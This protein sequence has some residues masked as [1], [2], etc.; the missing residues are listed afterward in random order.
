MSDISFQC[1]ACSHDLV[2]DGRAAGMFLS[3]P[4]CHKP[5]VVPKSGTLAP[6]GARP[7]ATILPS[8]PPPA[9]P[10]AA[11]ATPPPA[12]PAT[13]AGESVAAA[14]AG[15]LQY[16]VVA[17]QDDEGTPGPVD[18][19]RIER[20]LNE[21]TA[22]GWRFRSAATVQTPDWLGHPKQS[23]LLIFDRRA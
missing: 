6:S 15:P 2:V 7:R 22:A 9:A 18:P 10:P 5:L 13:T 12:P 16:K 4:E 14:P 20:K 11:P 1:P 8:A 3:C 23:V 21:L 17:V 19:A